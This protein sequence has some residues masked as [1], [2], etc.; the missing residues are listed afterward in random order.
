[1]IRLSRCT[2]AGL[3]ARGPLAG[4]AGAVRWFALAVLVMAP[5]GSAFSQGVLTG[6]ERT[7]MLG[8]HNNAR[9]SKAV[10][11]LRWSGQLAQVAADWA[12]HLANRNSC[13]MRHR[14]GSGYGEN[15]YWSSAVRW[16][17]GERA[18]ARVAPRTVV[19]SWVGEQRDYDARTNRCRS[20]RVCGHYTQVVWQGTTQVGCALSVCPDKA[21]I[22]VC[23]Y[24]PPGNVV[25]QRPFAAGDGGSTSRGT[26]SSPADQSDSG[27]LISNAPAPVP[28]VLPS[29]SRRRNSSNVR[30]PSR[31][32]QASPHRKPSELN[33]A[34]R[35]RQRK[36]EYRRWKKEERAKL[37]R[38]M[39]EELM[40]LKKK[41][42]RLNAAERKK[43]EAA[44]YRRRKKEKRAK[45]QRWMME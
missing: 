23:N 42:S 16:S 4:C 1:M 41:P 29:R 19:N 3:T 2:F 32:Q 44:E 7:N 37:K 27:S 40:Q 33:A 24:S 6:G 39:M 8:A 31:L 9:R 25:G 17:S 35:A 11:P 18:V 43:A 45:R 5:A 26:R 28:Y 22:W 15:L 13:R 20:G 30:Q 34:E 14:S 36:A 38:R 12:N 21:Q 10:P